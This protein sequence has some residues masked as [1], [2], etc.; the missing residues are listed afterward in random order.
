MLRF[1]PSSPFVTMRHY[2]SEFDPNESVT[3]LTMN[4]LKLAD[5]WKAYIDTFVD[6]CDVD[7]VPAENRRKLLLLLA[8]SKLRRLLCQLE[9]A[10][11]TQ[12]STLEDTVRLLTQHFENRKSIQLA[13]YNFFYGPQNR[14]RVG[15]ALNEWTSR[16]PFCPSPFRR[17]S[18]R[19]FF[20]TISYKI[21]SRPLHA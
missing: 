18:F 20:S 9:S 12:T 3:N 6:L 11:E 17:K 10:S 14:R 5:S 13:R 4:V 8:G 1:S 19:T 2:I 7:K 16:W 21:S 15:E